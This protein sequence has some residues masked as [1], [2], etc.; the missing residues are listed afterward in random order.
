MALEVGFAEIYSIELAPQYYQHCVQRFAAYPNVRIL[1]GDSAEL[2]PK[3]LEHIDAPATFWL[4]GH[5][6]WIDT[7]RGKTNSPILAELESIRQH[8]IKTHTIMIDDVR[9]FGTIH[10]DFI[11]LDDITQKIQEINPNYKFSFG[12]GL[13]PNDILIAEP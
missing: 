6:M 5:Y 3:I 11:E 12:A 2:L 13:I 7:A 9:Q 1:Q 10:F 4:D 8:G